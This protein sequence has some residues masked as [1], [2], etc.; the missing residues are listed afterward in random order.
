IKR[1]EAGTTDNFV[2]IP[3]FAEN[4]HQSYPLYGDQSFGVQLN[5][6]QKGEEEFE[7]VGYIFT[8]E[9]KLDFEEII[10]NEVLLEIKDLQNN[11]LWGAY[12]YRNMFYIYNAMEG[13][14]QKVIEFPVD[15]IDIYNQISMMDTEDIDYENR[16]ILEYV[17]YLVGALRFHNEMLSYR[18]DSDFYDIVLPGF[19]QFF[20]YADEVLDDVDLIAELEQ[21]NCDGIIDYL[22][23]NTFE[24]F[25]DL[26]SDAESFIYIVEGEIDFPDGVE[27]APEEEDEVD[28]E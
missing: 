1:G 25:I 7:D 13:D 27:G 4:E 19:D 16:E 6:V 21:A 18:I 20:V 22:M 12:I 5:V 15:I 10:N 9:L 3:F 11:K 23:A 26:S 28:T 14:Y 8:G 2:S 17:A 24:V